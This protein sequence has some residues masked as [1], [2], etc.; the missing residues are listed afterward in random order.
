MHNIEFTHKEGCY[1]IVDNYNIVLHNIGTE[2]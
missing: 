1:D 2:Q